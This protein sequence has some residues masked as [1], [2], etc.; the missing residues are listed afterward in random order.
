MRLAVAVPVAIG[1][2][3]TLA[4]IT[5]TTIPVA[6]A[7]ELSKSERKAFEAEAKAAYGSTVWAAKD[8][9]VN[10]GISMGF[11][12]VGPI[13]EVSPAGFKI[14]PGPM[15]S[16]TYGTTQTVWYSIRPM[17]TMTF[18]EVVFG[19]DAITL[20]LIG[21]GGSKGRDTKI[22]ITGAK[23]LAE[24]KPVLDQLVMTTSPLDQNPDWSQ[25]VKDAISKRICINGMTKR[26]AYLVVGEPTASTVE[27]KDGKKIETW[28][29]RQNNG[30]R[31]GFTAAIEQTGYP[32]TLRFEDGVLTGL[33]TTGTGGVS[34]D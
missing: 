17:D 18:K 23:T 29:P 34:L 9:P 10:T 20:V 28:T 6:E 27:E 21:S 22:K 33:G 31:I 32:Q 3:L 16:A 8:L 15:G 2:F 24:V 13:T 19:D 11:P 1:L 30:L 14:D 25:E 12:W 26:Q 5:L 7:T 4:P